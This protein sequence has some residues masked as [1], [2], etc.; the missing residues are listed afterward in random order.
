M[1]SFLFPVEAVGFLTFSYDPVVLHK[2]HLSRNKNILHLFQQLWPKTGDGNLLW[3]HERSED[4][5]YAT[6]SVGQAREH[7]WPHT[8]TRRI[9]GCYW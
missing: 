6:C 5:I 1:T 2:K 4:R 9:Q 3:R 8:W 7:H